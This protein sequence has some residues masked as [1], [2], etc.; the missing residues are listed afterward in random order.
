VG[1]LVSARWMKDQM[2]GWCL[3]CSVNPCRLIGQLE[4]PKGPQVV[5]ICAVEIVK[6]IFLTRLDKVLVA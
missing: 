4:D 2:E 3:T 5:A 1:H 6:K